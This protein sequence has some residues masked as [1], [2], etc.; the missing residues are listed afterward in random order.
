MNKWWRKL[1]PGG[2]RLALPPGRVTKWFWAI[3]V[4]LSLPFMIIDTVGL[5]DT[6]VA[7]GATFGD[8]ALRALVGFFALGLAYGLLGGMLFFL[9]CLFTS[10]VIPDVVSGV[11]AVNNA[12][13]RTPAA[14][15]RFREDA[16]RAASRVRQRTVSLLRVL[17]GIPVKVRAMTAR[18]WLLT[19]YCVLAFA[20]LAGMLWF[21]WGWAGVVVSWLPDWLFDDRRWFLQAIVDWFICMIPWVLALSVLNAAFKAFIRRG[22]KR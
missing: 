19:L 10:V 15:Q 4:A 1:L 6:A 17:T 13:R 16:A 20:L 3:I 5:Y 2:E 22:S 12:A 21:A 7:Q 18:D 14:W 11:R 8:A 9:V